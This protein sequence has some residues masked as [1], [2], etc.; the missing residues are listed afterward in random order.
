MCD[1]DAVVFFQG[2]RDSVS[3]QKRYKSSKSRPVALAI[4]TNMRGP[5][6][7]KLRNSKKRESSLEALHLFQAVGHNAKMSWEEEGLKQ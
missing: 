5:I 2:I 7:S 4:P 1:C 3:T 6:A